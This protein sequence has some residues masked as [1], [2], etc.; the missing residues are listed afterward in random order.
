MGPR[1]SWEF[2]STGH[3][4]GSEIDAEGG[5]AEAHRESLAEGNMTNELLTNE[6]LLFPY[7]LFDPYT[8]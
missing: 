6:K 2:P 8:I 5:K 7:K 1:V 4:P 3:V